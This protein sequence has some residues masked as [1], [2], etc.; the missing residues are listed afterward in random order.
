[1]IERAPYLSALEEARAGLARAQ[2]SNDA[3]QRDYAR[4]SALAKRDVSS[5]SAL[6]KVTATRDGAAAAV[7]G[8]K[9]AL[10]TAQLDLSYTEM[11]AP[12]DGRIGKVSVDVGNLVGA[13]DDTVLATLVQLD[14]L[15]VYFGA[16]ERERLEVLKRRSEGDF[17]PRDQIEARLVLADGSVFPHPG[18]ID[19]V[20]N[21]VD[22]KAGTV[23]VRVIVPNPEKTLLPGQYAN[24]RLL[25]GQDRK[26][27]LVPEQALL[28]DQGGSYVLV[29]QA[30]GTVQSRAVVAAER[31]EGMR[32]IHSGLAA[33]ELVL[34]D[35]LQQAR[36]ECGSSRRSWPRVAS[37][38]SR[39]APPPPPFHQH[40][41]DRHDG[42]REEGRRD[43]AA[44]DRGA[45]RVARGGAGAGRHHQRED[46]E[47][48]GERRHQ[49][50]AQAHARRMDRRLLQRLAALVEDLGELDDQ[51]RVLA[52]QADQHHQADLAEHVVGEPAQRLRRERPEDRERHHQ[53]H[54]EG[55]A[56]AL[57][58]RGQTQE[59]DDQRERE[60]HRRLPARL[61]LLVDDARPLVAHALR[62]HAVRDLLHAAIASPELLPRAAS[63]L[64][65]AVRKR[66]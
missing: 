42:E 38:R 64:M 34:I 49:D 62:Q 30:D 66:L 1:M 8:A 43:H 10:E 35:H 7:R 4:I 44:E 23:R 61:E 19:F 32:V 65:A 9:A 13:G 17:V 58:E 3:A 45:E 14:P 20:D 50:R 52:R 46:A 40:E 22:P 15:Y 25:M 28:S 26:A 63:P 56:P 33:E 36:P 5:L 37:A 47:D 41:E 12:F 39:R 29:A 53:H 51:D 2:A 24:V 48:E 59:H 31:I 6:D 54:R 57:V 18:R 55:Q 16:P 11:R 21:T 27:L 60:D